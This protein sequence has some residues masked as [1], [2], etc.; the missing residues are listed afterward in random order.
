MTQSTIGGHRKKIRV[1]LKT[2][3]PPGYMYALGEGR[4]ADLVVAVRISVIG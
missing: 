1:R 2:G 4:L 3:P